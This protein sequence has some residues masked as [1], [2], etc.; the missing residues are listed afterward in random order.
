M[1]NWTKVFLPYTDGGSQ[2]GDL[3]E[4]VKVGNST[5]FYRGHRILKAMIAALKARG[6]DAATEVIVSG[7]SAG[8]LA[9]FLHADEWG[10]A[11][12]TAKVTAMP[13]R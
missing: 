13:D 6:L 8:G 4:P 9:A 2:T 1:W 7:C 11:F 5:I 3:A 12:P 10:S